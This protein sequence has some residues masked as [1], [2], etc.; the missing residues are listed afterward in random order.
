M[1]L[2]LKPEAEL[3]LERIFEYSLIT[4]GFSQAEEYQDDL[5]EAMNLISERPYIGKV[6][7]YAQLEYRILHVNRHLVFYRIDISTCE[8]V[9][10]LHDAMDLRTHLFFDQ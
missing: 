8:I 4:W 3:D 9:R 10:V 2:V 5:Y 7:S 6:Y 1:Q